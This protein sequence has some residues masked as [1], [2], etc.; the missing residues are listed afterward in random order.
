MNEGAPMADERYTFLVAGKRLAHNEK[1]WRLCTNRHPETSGR[2]WGWI[3]NAPGNVTWSDNHTTG[4]NRNAAAEAVRMHNSWLEEQKPVSIRLIEAD[5]R[6][7]R[8]TNQLKE[9]NEALDKAEREHNA[10]AA[11]VES[12]EAQS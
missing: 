6:L 12:L 4:F 8:A 9:A 5:E 11:L 2:D 1:P 3:E 7:R 10:A